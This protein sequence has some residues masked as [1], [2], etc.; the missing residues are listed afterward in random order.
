MTLHVPLGRHS[1]GPQ[2]GPCPNPQKL[3]MWL[4]DGE[5][6]YPSGPRVIPRVLEEGGCRRVRVRGDV[7]MEAEV[8]VMPPEEGSM[9][10]GQ[11]LPLGTDSAWSL[12]GTSSTNTWTSGIHKAPWEPLPT[13]TTGGYI[14]AVLSHQVY[15]HCL[16]QPS[17]TPKHPR[18]LCLPVHQSVWPWVFRAA[19]WIITPRW[20]QSK[21]PQQ[22][23]G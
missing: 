6:G 15:G 3:G 5:T 10:C 8:T 1:S 13:R 18:E 11:R 2:R 17:D 4:C 16:Q 14:C 23:K 9:S 20:K 22:V 21:C 12:Q 7:R 19:L